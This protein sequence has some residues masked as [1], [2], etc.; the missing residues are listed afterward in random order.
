MLDLL[1]DMLSPSELAHW[2]KLSRIAERVHGPIEQQPWRYLLQRYCCDLGTRDDLI[3]D[4]RR[5]R[6]QQHRDLIDGMIAELDRA[7]AEVEPEVLLMVGASEA[8]ERPQ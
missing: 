4:R 6:T 3:D 5:A 8:P 1:L 2:S 7:I